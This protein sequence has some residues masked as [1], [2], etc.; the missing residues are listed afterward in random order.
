[1]D[2]TKCPLNALGIPSKKKLNVLSK[3]SIAIP[4]ALNIQKYLFENLFAIEVGDYDF[5]VRS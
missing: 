3:Y 2:D 1:M 4:N 5:E